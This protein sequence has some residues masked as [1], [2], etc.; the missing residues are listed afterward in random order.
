[1]SAAGDH[2]SAIAKVVEPA[3][4]VFV[5]V[6]GATSRSPT[7]KPFDSAVPRQLTCAPFIRSS[8]PLRVRHASS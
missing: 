5:S 7:A 1:M 3:N 4:T 2:T 6:D 8:S